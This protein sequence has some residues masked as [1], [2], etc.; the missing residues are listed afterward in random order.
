MHGVSLK[1]TQAIA[2]RQQWVT[3]GGALCE[4]PIAVLERTEAEYLTGNLVCTTCGAEFRRLTQP[5][6]FMPTL[7]PKPTALKRPSDRTRSRTARPGAW[8]GSDKR[9]P[10]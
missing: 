6:P 3:Q 7:S 4:H 2:L 5:E 1:R 10:E 8:R 9:R